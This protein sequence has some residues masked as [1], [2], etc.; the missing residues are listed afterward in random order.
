M[1]PASAGVPESEEIQVS[2]VHLGLQ[3][4]KDQVQRESQENEVHLE[5]EVTRAH[6]A[7]LESLDHLVRLGCQDKKETL[8]LLVHQDLQVR[9]DLLVSMELKVLQDLQDPKE[10]V[11]LER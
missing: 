9:S 6:Q 2:Q 1:T 5:T 7:H 10:A 11:G 3:G 8:D 4:I